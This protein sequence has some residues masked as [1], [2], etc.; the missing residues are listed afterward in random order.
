LGIEVVFA[1]DKMQESAPELDTHRI[2][3]PAF[4]AAWLATA[5]IAVTFADRNDN[6]H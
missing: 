3:L 6:V 2:P 5:E 1:P 4:A